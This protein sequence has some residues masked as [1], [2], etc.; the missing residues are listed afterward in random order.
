MAQ[1]FTVNT[2]K[3]GEVTF[4][5]DLSDEKVLEVLYTLRGNFP[6]TLR[7]YWGK[8]SPSQYAWAHKLAVDSITEAGDDDGKYDETFHKLF[9]V[10]NNLRLKGAKR[11]KM[12]FA[13]IAVSPNKIGT[14]LYVT[15]LTETEVGNYGI[16]P[17]YLGK[18]CNRTGM[19]SRLPDDV[20]EVLLSAAADP[21]TAA[22]RYGRES[23]NCSCCGRELTDPRSIELGI[24][25]ICKDKFGL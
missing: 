15:S 13:E 6:R 3:D 8:L 9:E 2:R 17:K 4:S 16:Q 22:I 25:P 21:L 23:G 5:S 24:G 20:K 11:M 14:A 18:I 7:S 12:R 10:F 19:D 1:V